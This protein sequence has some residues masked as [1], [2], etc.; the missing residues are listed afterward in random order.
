MNVKNWLLLVALISMLCFS[1]GVG[2]ATV[3]TGDVNVTYVE[4]V[5]DNGGFIIYVS[6]LVPGCGSSSGLYVYPGQNGVSPDGLKA[7]YAMALMAFAT[8]KKVNAM[9][10]NATVNCFTRY[11]IISK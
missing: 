6:P 2:A 9:Y 10:D 4:A 3:W 7:M 8:G 5:G 11:L 1:G